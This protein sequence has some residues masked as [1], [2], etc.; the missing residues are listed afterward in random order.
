LP[1]AGTSVSLIGEI[2]NVTNDEFYSG[3][4]GNRD[5]ANFGEPTGIVAGSQRRF[6][7]GARLR[8]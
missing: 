4:E 7:Y 1:I 8:F 3:Y 6:Q 2:F 5:S